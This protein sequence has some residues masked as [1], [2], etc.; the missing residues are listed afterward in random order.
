MF[1]PFSVPYYLHFLWDGLSLSYDSE[2]P[3]DPAHWLDYVAFISCL[4]F[5]VVT[6][7]AGLSTLVF[8][9][10]KRNDVLLKCPPA[11]LLMYLGALLQVSATMVSYLPLSFLQTTVTEP[12]CVVLDYWMTV[13]GTAL[14][15]VG[16]CVS[17]S[18]NIL[19]CMAIVERKIA[20]RHEAF[21]RTMELHDPRAVHQHQASL[22]GGLQEIPSAQSPSSKPM[23]GFLDQEDEVEDMQHEPQWSNSPLDDVDL[24]L[25]ELPSSVGPRWT[26]DAAVWNRG[27]ML[28]RRFGCAWRL[29]PMLSLKVRSVSGRIMGITTGALLG[30][31]VL[32]LLLCFAAQ[33]NHASSPMV[34][35]NTTVILCESRLD[36][37]FATVLVMISYVA[38]CWVLLLLLRSYRMVPR[39]CA[40]EYMRMLGL[41]TGLFFL[42]LVINFFGATRYYWGRFVYIELMLLLYTIAWYCLCGRAWKDVLRRHRLSD[43]QILWQLG[44]YSE[45]KTFCDIFTNEMQ[46]EFLYRDF[47]AW[48]ITTAQ[49]AFVPNNM[50]LGDAV[51]DAGRNMWDHA[52]VMPLHGS[53]PELASTHFL[54]FP[55]R[56][57]LLFEDAAKYIR[58]ENGQE[59]LPARLRQDYARGIGESE[60]DRLSRTLDEERYSTGLSRLFIT[61]RRSLS[62]LFRREDQGGG[63]ES[64]RYQPEHYNRVFHASDAI[65]KNFLHA[66]QTFPEQEHL[67]RQLAA[68]PHNADLLVQV[69][70]TLPTVSCTDQWFNTHMMDAQRQEDPEFFRYVYLYLIGLFDRYYFPLFMRNDRAKR[71]LSEIKK[72]GEQLKQAVAKDKRHAGDNPFDEE[73]EDGL[74]M[75]VDHVFP[76]H[77]HSIL[78][79]WPPNPRRRNYSP[80]NSTTIL[81]TAAG[82]MPPADTTVAVADDSGGDADGGGPSQ[83]FQPELSVA[84]AVRRQEFSAYS[85]GGFSALPPEDDDLPD[86]EL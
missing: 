62:K 23:S 74:S 71:K 72:T 8:S 56:L 57:L 5:L 59:V 51:V 33:T 75:G 25:G 29:R 28:M 30:F 52:E 22:G 31:I 83:P 86:L 2:H 84:V 70:A 82:L 32:F 20:D 17:L 41:L 50:R 77:L 66:R 34:G 53:S 60:T 15:C 44:D 69:G 13:G 85:D 11:Q 63:G 3:A 58:D 49:P 38:L 6:L 27:N 12:A 48:M 73:D 79:Y 42:T 16:Y 24:E 64:A 67:A 21:P 61:A 14:W 76:P 68:A 39:F 45:P 18:N 37:K 43:K 78:G 65:R 1:N 54:V 80:S 26:V 7:L 35:A 81:E 4:V 19:G 55:N 46:R 40:S 47:A 10:Q 9:L 36:F